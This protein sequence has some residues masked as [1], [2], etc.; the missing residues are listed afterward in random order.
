VG[1]FLE[2]G[3]DLVQLLK[4]IPGELRTILKQLR[5]GKASVIFEHRGLEN[6]I[7]G[8]DRSSNRIA[9]SLIISSLIIG[10]SL[11][12]RTKIG[13]FLFGFPILGLRVSVLQAF[14]E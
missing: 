8:L 2:S 5:Q 4:D 6:L 9:S 1:D 12:I 10:S 3:E 13:P 11:I 14:L 7:S